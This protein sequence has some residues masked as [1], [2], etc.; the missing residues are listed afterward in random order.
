MKEIFDPAF[1]FAIACL[2][3]GISLAAVGKALLESIARN[4]E[5]AADLKSQWIIALAFCEAIA[6]YG[7]VYALVK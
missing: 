5:A 6:I 7:L 2:A 3:S 1:T 4:P